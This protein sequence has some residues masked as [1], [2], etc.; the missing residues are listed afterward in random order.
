MQQHKILSWIALTIILSTAVFG[1]GWHSFDEQ[2][3]SHLLIHMDLR[4]DKLSNAGIDVS[5]LT[6]LRND[7]EN[8]YFSNPEN[9]LLESKFESFETLMSKS[10]ST[11]EWK[12]YQ[13][14]VI[15][16]EEA[17]RE[18]ERIQQ[19]HYRILNDKQ[20]FSMNSF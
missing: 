6:L 7:F 10:F 16:E 13:E 9:P 3:P 17:K 5:E 20:S 1:D 8:A 14:R 12:E 15:V 11:P 4:I 18:A 2:S 19:E